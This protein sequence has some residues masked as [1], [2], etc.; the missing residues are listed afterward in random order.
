MTGYE[1]AAVLAGGLS[2]LEGRI[3]AAR[4]DA[5]MPADFCRIVESSPAA[6]RIWRGEV[7]FAASRRSRCQFEQGYGNGKR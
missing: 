3:E 6:A 2:V 4:V 7:V 1:Q 5:G